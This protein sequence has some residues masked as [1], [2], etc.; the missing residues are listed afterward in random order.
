M[1][2]GVD[3]VDIDRFK[4]E[5][6]SSEALLKKIFTENEIHYCEEKPKPSQHYAARFA[7]KEA[8]I[9][10]LYHYKIRIPSKKIEILNDDQGIPFVRILDGN[11]NYFDV[12]ISLSHSEEIAIAIAIVSKK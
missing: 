5:N 9:K 10:A 8:V 11:L 6:L 12:K 4:K 1:E 7:G 3:C 2:I